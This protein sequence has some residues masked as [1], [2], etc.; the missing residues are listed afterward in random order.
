MGSSSP[1]DAGVQDVHREW[2]QSEVQPVLHR[3]AKTGDAAEVRVPIDPSTLQP[4]SNQIFD[5][6]MQSW[7]SQAQQTYC[8]APCSYTALTQ[9]HCGITQAWRQ[10]TRLLTPRHPFSLHRAL[11]QHVQ[12]HWDA[13]TKVG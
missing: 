9:N 1:D 10:L 8:N 7:L 4:R 13:D 12:R 2:Y 6:A 5:V 3:L 11:L